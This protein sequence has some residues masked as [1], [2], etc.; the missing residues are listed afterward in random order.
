MGHFVEVLLV[1][2]LALAG[3][4]QVLCG[5]MD[6][7][8]KSSNSSKGHKGNK[9]G[10]LEGGAKERTRDAGGITP[11]TSQQVFFRLSHDG[12]T[13][14]ERK[15][16][17][18]C[19]RTLRNVTCIF[20]AKSKPVPMHYCASLVLSQPMYRPCDPCP[21]DCAMTVWSGWSECSS[22]C[23]PATRFRTRR[24]LTAARHGGRGCG[25]LS[26]RG[27][28]SELPDCEVEVM[29]P[30]YT[31]KIGEWS[32]CRQAA[33]HA[34]V[35]C[36]LGQRFRSI[37]CVDA[38]GEVV[39][40]DLCSDDQDPQKRGMQPPSAETCSIPC[41]CQTSP[42]AAWGVCS[43]TCQNHLAPAQTGTV[44]TRTREIVRLP[45]NGGLP[46]PSLAERRECEGEP[47][48]DCPRFEWVAE[49]WQPCRLS[50]SNDETCGAG[51]QKR[52]VYC[53]QEGDSDRIPVTNDNCIN[54]PVNAT[55]LEPPGKRACWLACPVDCQ[56]GEWQSWSPCSQSCQEGIQVRSREILVR[57]AHG[58]KECGPL[59]EAKEC[60][61]VECA[62]WH[63]SRWSKCFLNH[64][65]T[66]CGQGSHVR[67]V[68]C[69]SALD[70]LLEDEEC[71]GASPAYQEECR[72]PCPTDCVISEWTDWGPCSKSC[73]KKGGT[74]M[75]T[76]QILAYSDLEE[77]S[78]LPENELTQL[79]PCN[80]HVSCQSY[81]WQ[82]G[83]W[84]GCIRSS[85]SE[86]GCGQGAGIKHREV[87]CEKETGMAPDESYCDPASKPA[88]QRACDVPCPIDCRLSTWSALSGCSETCGASGM[89]VQ[90]QIIVRLPAHG[91]TP[92]PSEADED[93][94]VVR[95]ESCDDLPPCYSYHW[96]AGNWTDCEVVGTECGKG[97]QTREV[98]C[99]RSDGTTVELGLCLRELLSTPPPSY[100]Q[101]LV[102]C[103]GDCLLSEW[104]VFGPCAHDCGHLDHSGYC[105]MRSRTILSIAPAIDNAGELCPHIADSDLRNYMSCDD[106]T[107]TY[108]WQ[109]G[110][111]QSCL[112]QEGAECGPGTMHRSVLCRRSD[113]VFV[114]DHFCQVSAAKPG[115]QQSC[116]V[117]CPVDCIVSE[118][119]DWSPC[120]QACGQGIR[121]RLRNIQQQSV[122]GGRDCPHLIDSMICME[123]P[124]AQLEWEV[125]QWGP[126]ESID[127]RSNCG[128]G[129]Q[130]RRV[131]C[132]A[133]D[134]FEEECE[135]R[136]PKPDASRGCV[137]PCPGDC[138][139]TDWS[140]QT[141]CP[142][143][144]Q[145]NSSKSQIRSVI[146][147]PMATGEQCG[148]LTQTVL[149]T[150]ADCIADGYRLVT[151][152]WIHCKAVSGEC[153]TGIRQ[154]TFNCVNARGFPVSMHHCPFENITTSET[155]DVPCSVTC[156]PGKYS[157]WSPCSET[158]GLTG[159]MERSRVMES[160]Y[161]GKKC[162]QKFT[163]SQ[164]MPCNS[165]PC[166]TYAW[167]R[168]FWS[169]CR[170]E[171]ARGC[172]FGE[173]T[174]FVECL[175]S[176]G[177]TV[178][179]EYCIIQEFPDAQNPNAMNLFLSTANAT[180]LNIET[181]QRCEKP[182][183]GDCMMS[184]WSPQT[185]CYG[186]CY[187]QSD[188]PYV[189]R[190]RAVT[191]PARPGGV[192][193]PENLI[194]QR[195]CP[196]D[197]AVCPNFTW[198]TG[199]FDTGTKSREVWCQI[200]DGSTVLNVTGGCVDAL[201]PSPV[202][203]CN[204]Q[205]TALGAVC[206]QGSCRCAEGFE[207]NGHT[208][209]P[210]SG[211][212][213]DDHCPLPHFVC[214]QYGQCTCGSG[215]GLDIASGLCVESNVIPEG[216]GPASPTKS[217]TDD[218]NNRGNNNV[219]QY[220]SKSDFWKWIL[221]ASLLMLALL[222][223][224]VG[225]FLIRRRRAREVGFNP[226]PTISDSD[227]PLTKMVKDVVTK[228]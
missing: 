75:R 60:E 102:T 19:G 82:V 37:S 125:S 211:C 108:E 84:Q 51:R 144:C 217:R 192:P 196:S 24:V 160:L 106:E 63:T 140:D 58:G 177:L 65:Q 127:P 5:S 178:D 169:E 171:T 187:S 159:V 183:P 118:W 80:L 88:A 109:N 52:Q 156:E 199:P 35:G 206:D 93:G 92:C 48:P 138:V 15:N 31:W 67:T 166:H 104:T 209:F 72:I 79:R 11:P 143:P 98:H 218:R 228:C 131:S 148:D 81:T 149:C 141:H 165:V 40:N 112:L 49:E 123:M 136:L 124:C 66:D 87:T 94:L 33:Q 9:L 26:E 200:E 42:W 29:V 20:T 113:G 21:E 99:E 185:P 179:H 122:H 201:R 210:I 215:F 214:N 161:P 181:S 6:S 134:N 226:I 222:V 68:Y 135:E 155:C 32:S 44:Q 46:C 174:R 101:C 90:M 12:W 170:F 153:G 16:R 147:H 151:G 4:V 221:I 129:A 22:T 142:S 204:P 163:L 115:T 132:K 76:R 1:A 50:P 188:P 146:R 158:C 110:T 128:S 116:D 189:T 3:P 224:I 126:C 78:C 41:N 85:V 225:V 154:R 207:G 172:G 96:N 173:R 27:A 8:P 121:T 97:L 212:V 223:V 150:G 137:L 133:G 55:S 103:P 167:E 205:C 184:P 219:E 203:D 198:Q 117:P 39:D 86:A 186:S 164:T 227:F 77:D 36:G 100:Q 23:S 13:P 105:R 30:I 47:L 17:T 202:L 74:Q 152:E 71:P 175:R 56:L 182:C 213:T 107:F 38:Q 216:N 59:A 130:T 64:G 190:S 89:R 220:E 73:G 120:T 91:G 45:E 145:Q 119:I 197:Q 162:S 14:C 2:S 83:A 57:P 111:W 34:K 54:S 7:L 180:V 28:C 114:P 139:M 61:F 25:D 208:C 157:D 176:D 191:R 195:S 53:I 168:S 43:Q 70:E 62:W 69:M 10:P 18:S 193:C 95:V 194:D